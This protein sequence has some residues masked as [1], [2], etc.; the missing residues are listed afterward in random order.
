MARE[1]KLTPMMQQYFEVKKGLPANTLLLFRLGDFYEMFHED[2]EVG[3]QVLGITLTKRSDYKMAGIPFHAAEQYIGKVLK[4]GM[5]VAICDQVETPKAGKLVKRALTRILTP[6]TTIEDN[7]LDSQRNHFLAALEYDKAGFSL[8]WIDLS[9]GEFTIAHD[10]KPDDLLPVLVSIDPAELLLIEG[11]QENWQKNSHHN[12]VYEELIHFANSRATSELPGFQFDSDA[13]AQ[14]VMET[15]G[16]INLEGFGI[17]KKHDALGCAG[18]LLH[19]ATETLCAKPENLSSIH[20]YSAK[21]SLLI[22][23]AT[24]RNLEIFKSTRGL[25]E[26]SLIDAINGCKTA[27]GSR[28]LEKWLI[29]P[30]RDIDELNR[31][32]DCVDALYAN[33]MATTELQDKLKSV[34]DIKRILSRMQNR[35]RNPRE[36][37]GVRDTLAQIPVLRQLIEEATPEGATSMVAADVPAGANDAGSPP[38]HSLLALRDALHPLPALAELLDRALKEELPSKLDDGGY[39]AKGYDPEL[40]RMLSLTTDNKV[41]LAELESSERARTGIKNLKVKYNGA[42]GY[43]IEVTKSNLSLVPEE[44]IRKQTTVNAE[45]FITE[46]LKAKEK[47]IFHAEENSKRREE[48][49][50]LGLIEAVLEES[51][52]LTET[53]DA[54]AELDVYCGWSEIARRWDYCRPSLHDSDRID[55]SQ[56]RHPVVEQMLRKDSSGLAGS[57]AFVPNNIDISASE[58]QIHL[59]TGPNM[60]GKSTFIR[61]VALITLMAQIGCFVPAAEANIGLVDRIFSR[62]GASDD[63]ARGN[64]TFMVEMNETANILNNATERSLIILDEIG[65]GTSTYDGLSIAWSVIEHLHRDPDSGPKTLFATHYQELTQLDKHLDRLENYSV[66]V[67]EW[68]DEIVFVRQVVKGAADRSYGIQVARLAGLPAP[69]IDRAKEILEKLESEDATVTVSA[70]AKAPVAKPRK[71]I[72][73]AKDENQLGLF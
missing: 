47:E 57:H 5:K 61:Q 19:Y 36:L 51:H 60:A 33:P 1:K 23:P 28:R 9:T 66:A 70:P 40:D 11:S 59:I 6:G 50:F 55:I 62:V 54:L 2:A 20:E 67:K 45:R 8:A 34:R 30:E 39:I 43:F 27:A 26:G 42:F 44:Y 46:D 18:A 29:A 31:R 68:N 24:L 25:R 13:G 63:L 38:T 73:V 3:A 49:L 53:A 64:S 32:L 72:K 71:K 65:R 48:E 69:V 21:E 17:D 52:A 22:D 16:V 4:A 12:P 7:Q 41:W 10:P 56:G 37:G 58:N 35:L 15:L 14:S